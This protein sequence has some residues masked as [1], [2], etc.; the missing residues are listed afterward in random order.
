[1]IASGERPILTMPLES[2]VIW[3][4][5]SSKLC[6]SFPIQQSRI[7]TSNPSFSRTAARYK[8]PKD[9]S[10]LTTPNVG[11]WRWG[12]YINKNLGSLTIVFIYLFK[13]LETDNC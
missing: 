1:M 12:A 2:G 11:S 9:T 13:E 8:L 3:L 4:N 6:R 5:D 7:S 10:G